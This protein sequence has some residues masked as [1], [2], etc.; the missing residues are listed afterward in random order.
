MPVGTPYIEPG[1]IATDFF[2]LEQGIVDFT[3]SVAVAGFVNFQV[4]GVY[5]LKYGVVVSCTTCC[6]LCDVAQA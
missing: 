6:V 1:F 3:D 5:V 2:P 4:T